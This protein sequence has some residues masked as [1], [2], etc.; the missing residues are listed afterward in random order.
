MLNQLKPNELDD[1]AP[2]LALN[3]HELKLLVSR[4]DKESNVIPERNRIYYLSKI[5]KVNCDLMILFCIVKFS[6]FQFSDRTKSDLK[7]SC[8]LWI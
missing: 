1:M 7:V 6:Q 5:L 8:Q 4:F 2:L 3:E